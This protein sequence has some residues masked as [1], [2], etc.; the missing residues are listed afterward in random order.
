MKS[1]F[2]AAILA[3]TPITYV[4]VTAIHTQ[5]SL[6]QNVTYVTF[7]S[8]DVIGGTLNVT[9]PKYTTNISYTGIPSP[10]CI[11][12]DQLVSCLVADKYQS[13]IITGNVALGQSTRKVVAEYAIENETVYATDFQFVNDI[14]DYYFQ[15]N[16]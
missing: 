9:L 14:Y 2:L 12:N 10:N 11:I 8:S 4:E 16:Y 6:L 1:I 3:L 15:V 13:L 5:V 7:A